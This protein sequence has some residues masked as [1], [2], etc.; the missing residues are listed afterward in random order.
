MKIKSKILIYLFTFCAVLLILLWLFQIVF[1]NDI[2]KTIK[3]NEMKKGMH[4][5]TTHIGSDTITDVVAQLNHNMGIDVEILLNDEDYIVST[6]DG[7][8]R[9]QLAD[10]EK[11]RLIELAEKNN[12]DYIEDPDSKSETQLKDK[13]GEK[14]VPES[15]IKPYISQASRSS[16]SG[17]P[18]APPRELE[19]TFTRGRNIQQI[20]YCRILN[21]PDGN[22]LTFLLTST[23]SPVD[24]TVDALR[25][26]FFFIAS[27]MI[28]FS[29]ILS[30]FIARQIAT[31]IVSINDSAR[32]LARGKY[33]VTFH[34]QGYREICEL[35]DT[36]NIAAKELSTVENLR[37]ELIAN[38]SH[39]LKTPLTLIA[40][41]AEVMRD[42]PDE[43]T[44]EN[45]QII[46]DE[47]TRLNKLVCDLLDLSKHQSGA[48]VPTL[49]EYN[50]TKSLENT[51]NRIAEMT[52]NDGYTILFEYDSD[53]FLK[54]DESQI[55]QVIYNLLMNAINF[56]GKDKIVTVRQIKQK[57]TVT[58]QVIDSGKGI[59][60]DEIPYIWDRYYRTNKNH[61]RSSYGSGIGLSIVKS[62]IEMHHG[63]YGVISS[64]ETGSIF[65][66][67]LPL[68]S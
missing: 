40:G 28:L 42:L 2:Y 48:L 46:V 52:K 6:R 16:A 31:P 13:S 43:N 25:N 44:P 58:I 22:N 30:L 23:I 27:F 67:S 41:Y 68:R 8:N 26:E 19:R 1:L 15:T 24:A 34:A 45:A 18:S 64:K 59:D 39:D 66:V 21:L 12:N 47:A 36:L 61:Q 54:A 38:V 63:E 37:Q 62:I 10:I 7:N 32:S 53:V 65:W 50:L 56:T 17:S 5:I 49:K 29:I 9:S 11:K 55:S 33:D 60:E 57:N 4:L 14:K 35:S 3:I 51:I 20:S